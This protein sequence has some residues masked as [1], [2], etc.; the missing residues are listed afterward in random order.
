[1]EN[2]VE[3]MRKRIEL[4]KLGSKDEKKE[5]DMKELVERMR[6]RIEVWKTCKKGWEKEKRYKKLGG[7]DE[8]NE[9]D[10]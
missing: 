9:R 7:K 1:M 3:R 5:K 4:W 6:K 8:E 10:L 2:L